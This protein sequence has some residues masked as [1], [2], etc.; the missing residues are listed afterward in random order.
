MEPEYV[1]DASAL[2]AWLNGESGG[3]KVEPILGVS[4]IST[5]NLSETIQKSLS[6]G[7]DTD[8]LVEDLA[9]LGLRSTSFTTEDA[10]M[11]ASLWSRTRQLGLSLADRCCLATAKRFGVPALTADADWQHI[12]D[13]G[14]RIQLIR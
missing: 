13:S 12:V 2:L 14:L 11:A 1:L 10:E 4:A 6:R 9:A 5:V 3:E 8:G 7:V